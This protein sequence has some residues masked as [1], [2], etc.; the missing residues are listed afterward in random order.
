[1][2]NY[3]ELTYSEI[4]KLKKEFVTESAFGKRMSNI[5]KRLTIIILI[6]V[7]IFSFL[8]IISEGNLPAILDLFSALC[9]TIAVFLAFIVAI[10]SLIATFAYY[11]WV[12]VNKKIKM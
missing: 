11:R 1:M 9:I 3:Y 2:K 12:I 4:S 5:V 7:F 10:V 6:L 8:I